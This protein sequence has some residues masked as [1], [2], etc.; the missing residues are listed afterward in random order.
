MSE[1]PIESPLVHIRPIRHSDNRVVADVI[2]DVMAEFDCTGA[3]YSCH[4]PEVDAMY[5][6]Y[7]NQ[8]SVFYVIEA[9]GQVVGC[10]GIAPLVGADDDI[11]CELRK[12][13]FRTQ[14]RGLGLGRKLLRRCLSEAWNLGF[15]KCYIESVERM[16]SAISLYQKFGFQ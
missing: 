5:E 10:G 14:I 12:M 15:R 16:T 2:R 13:Y 7:S 6:A 4:D 9:Q 1:N 11:T 3:G 8:R